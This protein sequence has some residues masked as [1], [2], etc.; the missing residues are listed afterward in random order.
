MTTEIHVRFTRTHDAHDAFPTVA[1]HVSGARL[2]EAG[3]EVE[4]AALEEALVM[5]EIEHAL[6]EWLVERRLPFAPLCVGEHT[7]LVR[8]PGD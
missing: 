4:C 7:L 1:E 2:D 5:R 3:I 8:P 6:D